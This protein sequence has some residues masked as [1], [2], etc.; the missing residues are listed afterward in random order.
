MICFS[1]VAILVSSTIAAEPVGSIRGG[2]MFGTTRG[3]FPNHQPYI[4]AITVNATFYDDFSAKGTIVWMGTYNGTQE[5][6]RGTS[7]WTWQIEVDYWWLNEDGSVIVGGT[8]QHSQLKD[9]IGGFTAIGFFDGGKNDSDF[10]N[11]NEIAGNIFI[12]V[13]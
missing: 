11:G 7:G 6:G 5:P 10:I 3:E 13:P 8:V 1:V 12:A 2:G 4:D 9:E